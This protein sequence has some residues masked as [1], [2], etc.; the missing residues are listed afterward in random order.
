[1]KGHLALRRVAVVLGAFAL[2]LAAWYMALRPKMLSVAVGPEGSTQIT[3][4]KNLAKVL[5]DTRQPFRLRIVE[6]E[7][8]AEGGELLDKGRVDLA[9]LR[10]D[11]LESKEARSIVILHKRAFA[12]VV[13]KDS[14][15][16]SLRD[17]AEKPIGVVDVDTDSYKAIVERIMSHYDVDE[18][19]LKLEPMKRDEI[20]KA[21]A[22][23]RIL[24]FLMVG[25]LASRPF[26]EMMSEMT[27][28]L[29]LELVVSGVPAHEAI[30]LRFRELH[31]SKIPEGV[32]GLEPEEEETVGLTL[33]LTASSRLSEQ[34]ATALTKSLMEVRTRLRSTQAVTYSIETPPVDEE[35]RF[36]PHA[37]TAAFV[38]SEAKT[39][40][41][42]Y[43]DH[44][45]LALFG[46]GIVG[47]SI[48]GLMSWAG[49]RRE[50]P[51]E[52]LGDE[53]RVLA[54]RLEAAS[55]VADVDAIQGDFDDLM[56]SVMREYGLRNLVEEGTPDPSP[57]FNTF[58]GVIARRRALLADISLPQAGPV[59][60]LREAARG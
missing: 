13:H 50:A 25:N 49:L 43:S 57:W 1:M 16:E 4:L 28:K 44:I 45:W 26:R 29:K 23:R 19:D 14:G 41:E 31:T 21:M 7:G 52:T 2:L 30:A 20:G 60:H 8:S 40:L 35:R 51:A 59:T 36:L 58:A 15:I 5:K 55:E 9:V 47:S 42:Q 38:N 39:L 10:S 53:M 48:A 54:A 34:T 32:F 46:V 11:D 24:G 17:I 3:Y 6:V 37:G 33:E 56:L 27:G 12:F 22:E 18:D